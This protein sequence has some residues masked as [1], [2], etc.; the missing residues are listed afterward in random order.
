[1]FVGGAPDLG[2]IFDVVVTAF[3]GILVHQPFGTHQ[4][5]LWSN[6]QGAETHGMICHEMVPRIWRRPERQP[7]HARA[8]EIAKQAAAGGTRIH[9]VA[10]TRFGDGQTLGAKS[11]DLVEPI[12]FGVRQ[13]AGGPYLTETALRV[14]ILRCHFLLLGINRG[15]IGAETV[16]K[17]GYGELGVS[18]A[19]MVALPVVFHHQLP[20]SALDQVVLI[21]NF[22]VAQIVRVEIRRHGCFHRVKPRRRFCR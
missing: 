5:F 12:D 4:G 15:R 2:K 7:A 3:L 11:G 17:Q 16:F 1:M 18:G 6:G 13:R 8:G 10:L 21:G 9:R 14:L 22:G 20:I 19:A